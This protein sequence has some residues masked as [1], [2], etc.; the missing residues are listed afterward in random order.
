ML[1]LLY[2]KLVSY[3]FISKFNARTFQ[4]DESFKPVKEHRDYYDWEMSVFKLISF[5][6]YCF[7]SCY[8]NIS[9]WV[10][11]LFVSNIAKW[12]YTCSYGIGLWPVWEQASDFKA[13]IIKNVHTRRR[14]H[15][16]ITK[17]VHIVVHGNLFRVWP[18]VFC[19]IPAVANP[20]TRGR[21]TAI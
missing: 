19:T 5:F 17:Y 16:F 18:N 4:L 8:C 3:L 21:V 1:W 6:K 10:V 12:Y 15:F 20:T 14:K 13:A 2:Y 7:H 9:Q 11:E